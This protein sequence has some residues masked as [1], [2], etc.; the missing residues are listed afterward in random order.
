ME[1]LILKRMISE[2]IVDFDRLLKSTY[3]D[4]GLTELEAFLLMELN[5]LKSKGTDFITPKILTKKLTIT[6]EQAVGLMDELMKKKYLN[7]ML[8]K[9][10]NGKQK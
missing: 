7:F 10:Q 3:K 4:L 8:V 1:V 2:G 9:G 6:E 5:S